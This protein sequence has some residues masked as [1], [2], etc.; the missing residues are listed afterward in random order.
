[1]PISASLPP[2]L[3]SVGK[4]DPLLD[5][6]L[7]MAARWAAAGNEARLEVWPEAVHGFTGFPID[8]ARVCVARQI[9]FVRGHAAP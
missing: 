3:F 1:M 6:S 2:A 9:A 7:F 8:L 5:D 4:L